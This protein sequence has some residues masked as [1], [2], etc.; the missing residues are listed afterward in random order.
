MAARD[1]STFAFDA[2]RR[3]SRS[4]RRAPATAPLEA[5][6]AAGLFAPPTL[7]GSRGGARR[8]P[9]PAAPR[10]RVRR[11]LGPRARSPPAGVSRRARGPAAPDEP[12]A[13]RP[14]VDPLRRC[15]GARPRR[16]SIAQARHVV[17]ADV[18][19]IGS[20]FAGVAD[21]ARA[22]AAGPSVAAARARPASALRDRRVVDAAG[23]PA[24]RGAGGPLRPAAR[25]AALEVGH[26]AAARIPRSAAASSAGSASSAT[27]SIAP[28]RDDGAHAR[29]LLVAASPHDEI[30]DTHWYRPDFD[31][32]LVR[33]AERAGAR[34]LDEVALSTC[35]ST[36]ADARARRATGAD[37]RCRRPRA[38]RRSTQRTARVPAP[39]AR[40][41]RAPAAMAAADAGPLHALRRRRALGAT[42]VT[43]DGE[44]RRI[45]W[46]RRR[47]TTFSRAAGSGCCGSPTASP[48]RAPRVTDALAARAAAREGAAAW[49]R[50]LDGSV[51]RGAVR[52]RASRPAASSTRRGSRSAA[53]VCGPALGAAAVGRRRHR[54]AALDRLSA[55]AAR[56]PA[57]RRDLARSARCRATGA[58]RARRSREYERPDARA[59]S[60]RPSSSWRRSTRRMGDFEL[61]KRL[62]LL[63]FAA[64]SFSETVRRLGQPGSARRDFCCATIRCSDRSCAA[65]A[66]ARAAALDPI[67]RRASAVRRIDRAIEPFDVAGLRDRTRRDWYPGAGRRTCWRPRRNS[68]P[69]SASWIDRLARRAAAFTAHNAGGACDCGQLT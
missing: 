4:S 67:G 13:A 63:Y 1:R 7:A 68:V 36:R 59:S 69:S 33:E 61:F 21:G 25:A 2:A 8:R 24:A 34:Y 32:F 12:R 38:V 19:I 50:L 26:L 49:E 57:P 20:G 30:A 23:Q 51:G 48:A 58:V 28:F 44:R 27:I 65:C 9:A 40:P 17:D 10:P 56:H 54:S 45:P 52:A 53:A 18:A 46:T 64:A 37:E 66:D 43:P 5:L 41:R 14:P 3:R 35:A 6:A 29:Q 39:R 22:A 31:H 11:P 15:G 60:M 62:T 42:L 16:M 47:C 55:D